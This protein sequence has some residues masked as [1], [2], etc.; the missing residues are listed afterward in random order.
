MV[1]W[2]GMKI[3][4]NLHP[5]VVLQSC[6]WIVFRLGLRWVSGTCVRPVLQSPSLVNGISG[7]SKPFDILAA[8]L[9]LDGGKVFNRAEVGMAQRSQQVCRNKN[10]DIVGF[11]SQIPRSFLL[12][13]TGGQV[14]Q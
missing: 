1:G 11:V 6:G 2:W 9:H 5:S 8:F 4:L 7:P 12:R 3:V 13:Q 14:P 10:A